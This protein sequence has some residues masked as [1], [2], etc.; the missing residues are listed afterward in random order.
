LGQYCFTNVGPT[1]TVDSNLG[2]VTLNGKTKQISEMSNCPGQIGPIDATEMV[3][4][5]VPGFNYTLNYQVVTCGDAFTVLSGA[6]IDFNGNYQFDDFEAIGFTTLMGNISFNFSIPNSSEIS[7]GL[8]RLRIQVQ[9]TSQ[10]V[11]NPCA[12]FPYGG[13]KDFTIEIVEQFPGYCNCGPTTTMDTELSLVYLKGENRD[14][15][16][17]TGCP[18]NTGPVN[19][20][21]LTAD[22]IIGNKYILNYTILT[23]SNVYPAT[24]SAWIDWNQNNIF[25]NWE[26]IIPFSQ[27]YSNQAHLF[28]VQMSTP[29]EVVKPGITRMR[30]QVQE[31][32]AAF[33]YPCSMFAF[34][35][36][37]D[38]SIEVKP[39]VNGGW[40]SWSACNATCGGGWQTRVCNNP[41]PS[42]EGQNC[43]GSNIGECNTASC[44][45]S[46]SAGGKVA[47]GIL[48]PLIIIGG[49]VGFYIYRKKKREEGDFATDH[50]TEPTTGGAAYQ[51]S[52]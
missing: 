5:V 2:P 6:W 27:V 24:S 33:I 12:S 47:A 23:C 25:D 22:V 48:V 49:L 40:S 44:G 41:I 26:Q 9:E 35:G 45:A 43:T 21:N 52:V 50:S 32:A 46:K 34:G 14:I 28:K 4:D 1:T 39:A 19:Y 31:T 7:Y 3:A 8:T 11:I 17:P 16:E 51:Q 37:K 29:E 36:T 20:T 10:T 15:L 38:F 13:T 30:V 18:G 42:E